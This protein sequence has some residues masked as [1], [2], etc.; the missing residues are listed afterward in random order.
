MI[1][2]RYPGSPC[3]PG[4]RAAPARALPSA[5]AAALVLAGG[6]PAASAQA[7]GASEPAGIDDFDFED[8]RRM[9]GELAA[10]PH[11]PPTRELPAEIA[12]LTYDENRGIRFRRER[13]LWHEASGA[14]TS[15][16][17]EFFHRSNWHPQRVEIFEVVDGEAR[18][19]PY[20]PGMY[21][22]DESDPPGALPPEFG[23]AGFRL[24]YPINRPDYADEV[25]VFL[26]ATYFRPLAQGQVYGVSA[27]GLAIDTA[28]QYGE[29][30]FPVFTRF[31]LVRPSAGDREVEAYALMDSRRAA[32]AY[33]FRIR[34]GQE[35]RVDVEAEIHP[36]EE[37]RGVG[38]APLTSMFWYGEADRR[39]L[40]DYRPE[41]HDSD[42]LLMRSGG[43]ERLWRPLFNPAM[44]GGS[45]VPTRGVHV[46]RFR[47][48]GVDG[49]GLMQRDRAFAN[50]Q[51]LEARYD[52][53]PSLW[54]EPQGEWGSGVVEL[55]EI[56]SG[57]EFADNIVAAWIP[58]EQPRPGEP[59]TYRYTLTA[60]TRPDPSLPAKTPG[61]I[62]TGTRFE[63]RHGPLRVIVDFEGDRATP[64]RAGSIRAVATTADG[65]SLEA[66]VM[67][68]PDT[69]GVRV[70]FDAPTPAN[71]AHP[72]VRLFL[73]DDLGIVSETWTFPLLPD[74]YPAH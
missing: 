38:L 40:R 24:H 72:D 46:S 49:F 36:R 43:G 55:V 53:R 45:D 51:D 64:D 71:E 52:D 60:T 11:Q 48:D 9:A 29:E 39:P 34:P 44:L 62:V 73:E 31:W 13:A 20:D 30:E 17:A 16:S 59:Q 58:D 33:R 15:F 18:A 6:A 57:D 2:R 54:V 35:T 61:A 10:A 42:G 37:L 8:V 12:E 25:I 50:Y 70:F 66:V 7:E 67:P 68:N 63:R 28:R 22:F 4:R 19:V 14:A 1:F 3:R 32:G 56:P 69:G 41:V 65:T 47:F 5:F 27:R 23:H 21:R 74:L 26:G